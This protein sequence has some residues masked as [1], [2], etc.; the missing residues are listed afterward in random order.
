[1]GCTDRVERWLR[2]QSAHAADS[3]EPVHALEL[4]FH[5]QLESS[6]EFKFHFERQPI[7]ELE[8]HLK[9]QL[10]VELKFDL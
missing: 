1:M 4:E 6:V 9:P 5:V 2:Q 3:P 8:F 7:L 10:V